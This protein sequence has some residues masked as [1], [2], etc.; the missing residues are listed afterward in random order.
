MP[1]GRV[2]S[3]PL[4]PPPSVGSALVGRT[5]TLGGLCRPSICANSAVSEADPVQPAP[6][7]ESQLCLETVTSVGGSGPPSVVGG[8]KGVARQDGQR[9]SRKGPEWE[10]GAFWTTPK[11]Q[12]SHSSLSPHLGP[13][14]RRA[15]SVSL[16]EGLS[17][18]AGAGGAQVAWDGGRRAALQAC[19]LGQLPA[20]SPSSAPHP[21]ACRGPISGILVPCMGGHAEYA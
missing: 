3:E 11:P 5:P 8:S 20:A 10:D 14:P 15:P 16:R 4:T 17:F 12:T 1:P 7:S 13:F 19:P 9:W 18:T 21:G 2:S 6:G